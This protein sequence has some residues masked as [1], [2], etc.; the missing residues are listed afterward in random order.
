MSVMVLLRSTRTM[1]KYRIGEPRGRADADNDG[2]RDVGVDRYERDQAH[3]QHVGVM[4]QDRAGECTGGAAALDAEPADRDRRGDE[5][6]RDQRRRRGA[7]QDVE[8]V[9]VFEHGRRSVPEYSFFVIA[10]SEAT[11]QSRVSGSDFG[12]LRSARNDEDHPLPTNGILFAITV[13]NSTLVS[14]GRLA[15]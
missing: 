2:E 10:R 1:R 6:K 14:S 13:M 9:P 4:H 11:K 5:E 3:E 8:F 12:L 15:M 7:E